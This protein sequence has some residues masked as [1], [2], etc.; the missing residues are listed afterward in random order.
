MHL[1]FS[2]LIQYWQYFIFF[3]FCNVSGSFR[4]LVMTAAPNLSFLVALGT[5][6]CLPCLFSVIYLQKFVMWIIRC[7][8]PFVLT[9][10]CSQRVTFSQPSFLI[11]RPRRCN[12]LFLILIKSV[13][14]GPIFFKVSMTLSSFFCQITSAASILLFIYEEIVCHSMPYRKWSLELHSISA[15]TIISNSIFLIF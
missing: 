9:L 14:F 6:W 8:S 12:R 1:I 15:S 11:I 7:F 2:V 4:T 3:F 5:L 10:I 13:L